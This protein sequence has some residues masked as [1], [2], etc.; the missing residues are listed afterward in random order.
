[1]KNVKK[2][3]IIIP[4]VGFTENDL[5]KRKIMIESMMHIP[6]QVDVENIARGP[7]FIETKKDE[8]DAYP[9]LLRIC[10]LAEEKEYDAILIYCMNDPCV[11][12]LNEKMKI[13]VYGPSKLILNYL[14]GFKKS[15][16]TVSPNK[17][18]ISSLLSNINKN[19]KIKVEK[20]LSLQM[21][22]ERIKKDL[23]FTT[24]KLLES[25]NNNKLE[26]ELILLGCMAFGGIHKE[27]KDYEKYHII[28]PVYLSCNLIALYLN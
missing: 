6:L 19:S 22:G 4:N 13:P 20:S 23:Q 24:F 2:L 18:M 26:K 25:I 12:L 14:Q 21:D 7:E 10:K 15:I 17:K 1:M 9:E 28:D 8:E 11:S 5:R 16:V 27:I 3:K